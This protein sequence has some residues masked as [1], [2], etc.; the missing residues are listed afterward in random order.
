MA[1]MAHVQQ[2][3]TEIRRGNEPNNGDLPS[4]VKMT[5]GS[6]F[7]LPYGRLNPFDH[8]I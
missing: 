7:L 3:R 1:T 5:G 6:E 2:K 8:L 4:T